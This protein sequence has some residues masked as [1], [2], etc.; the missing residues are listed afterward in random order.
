M[1][2]LRAIRTGTS[3]VFRAAASSIGAMLG[4]PESGWMFRVRFLVVLALSAVICADVCGADRM[5]TLKDRGVTA[6]WNLTRGGRLIV[7]DTGSGNLIWTNALNRLSLYGWNNYGGEK[8]WLGPQS[9]WEDRVGSGWPPDVFDSGAYDVAETSA[10]DESGARK[11]FTM[12]S[13]ELSEWGGRILRRAELDGSRKTVRITTWFR[14]DEDAAAGHGADSATKWSILQVPWT[15]RVYVRLS[16]AGRILNGAAD[17]G[18]LKESFL[19]R[20][21]YVTYEMSYDDGSGKVLCDG[22]LLAVDA[23]G[24]LL[25]YRL[26]K[27]PDRTEDD[28]FSAQVYSTGHVKL[29]PAG[30][31]YLELEFE[32]PL[33]SMHIVELSFVPSETGKWPEDVLREYFD[34]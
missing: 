10:P 23:A 5:V 31:P 11:S 21:G 16:G 30:G 27:V 29:P 20:D 28:V 12:I 3:S 4:K 13:P 8:M 32:V 17:Y 24:G 26:C 1:V 7:F 25:V 34:E 33:D 14:E 18:P 2:R 9:V 19:A 6:V 15:P 22:D